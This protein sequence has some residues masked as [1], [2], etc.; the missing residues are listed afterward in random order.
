[1]IRRI[2]SL[3]LLPLVLVNQSVC[4]AHW[5]QGSDIATP[6][7]HSD[8]PH[9][10]FPRTDHDHGRAE[11]RHDRRQVD[12][13]HAD[14]EHMGHHHHSDATGGPRGVALGG[15]HDDNAIYCDGA[16]SAE[17]GGHKVNLAERTLCA[18]IAPEAPHGDGSAPPAGTLRGAAQP[19]FHSGPI[20]LRTLTLR[21]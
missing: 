15:A 4:L 21:L 9:F 11:H 20:Y 17:R 13:K 2:V 8:R 5:H 6:H 12:R 14:R 1:M 10:H 19:A 16:M 18:A 7:G 3:L